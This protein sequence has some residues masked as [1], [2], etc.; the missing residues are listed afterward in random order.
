MNKH[1]II[2]LLA[3]AIIGFAVSETIAATAQEKQMNVSSS[4][5]LDKPNIVVT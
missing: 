3:V 5:K 1:I 4:T 2:I